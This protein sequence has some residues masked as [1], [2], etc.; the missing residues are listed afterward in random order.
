[1]PSTEQLE[2]E[3][4]RT[5]IRIE[6]KLAELRERLSP[7]SLGEELLGFAKDNG[8]REFVRNLGR[9]VADNPLPVAVMGIGLA[10]LIAAQNRSGEAQPRRTAFKERAERTGTMTNSDRDRRTAMGD[11]S[12]AGD[13]YNRASEAAGE[14]RDRASGMIDRARE[15]TS[16]MVDRARE[17]T[18]DMMGRARETVSSAMDSVQSAMPDTRGIRNFMQEQPI[19][20]AGLGIALGAVIGALIPSTETEQRYLGPTA[21]RAREQARD[22]ARE[23][24]ERGKDMAAEGWDEAKDAARRTWEDAKDEAQKS[25]DNT[26]ERVARSG[27]TADMTGTQSPLVPGQGENRERMA[28]ASSRDGGS[29]A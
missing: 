29:G 22:M 10:W 26:Q 9:Q 4:G 28:E 20:L 27:Q 25:W 18:S 8:G 16:D 5:R 11:T 24:W 13:M 17:T 3:A 12:D 2:H 1:M 15:T 7:A 21:N 6:E 23:Q 19:V 14:A